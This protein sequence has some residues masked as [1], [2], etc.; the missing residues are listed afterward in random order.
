MEVCLKSWLDVDGGDNSGVVYMLTGVFM[1]SPILWM[2][3]EALSFWIVRQSVRVA[4]LAGLPS[5]SSLVDCLFRTSGYHCCTDGLSE[6]PCCVWTWTVHPTQH[7]SMHTARG[8][9]RQS[10]IARCSSNTVWLYKCLYCCLQCFDAVGWAA[11]RA[12]GL[13]KNW[14]VGCWCVYLSGARCRLAYGPADA[15]ATHSVLLQ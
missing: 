8:N 1:L 13:Q 2:R 9:T 11:G 12:S 6:L 15:T 7:V 14:V 3:L 5:T 4:F 10:Y